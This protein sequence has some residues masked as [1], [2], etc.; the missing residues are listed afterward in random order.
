MIPFGLEALMTLSLPTARRAT[1]CLVPGAVALYLFNEGS[2]QVLTDYSGNSNGGQL[3]STTGADTNDPAWGATGLSF[4]GDDNV[5][6]GTA[7]GLDFANRDHTLT[8]AVTPTTTEIEAIAGKARLGTHACGLAQVTGKFRF[9]YRGA[10]ASAAVNADDTY[11]TGTPYTV[12]LMREAA[13]I[14]M[15]VNGVK[16]TATRTITDEPSTGAYPFML[17]TRPQGGGNF[18]GTIHA[19][20]AY[21]FALSPAQVA[22]THAALKGMLAPRGVTL[23]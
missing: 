16:Q 5:T 7:A 22:Q 21:P 18:N 14:S 12:T 8:V 17:G 1:K 11:A 10:G 13:V 9:D 23:A 20:I 19:A 2:G 15:Y 3:G 6:C 4:D